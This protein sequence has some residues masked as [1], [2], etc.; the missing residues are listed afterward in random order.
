M[1]KVKIEVTQNFVTFFV[2]RETRIKSN[3]LL[4]PTK[5]VLQDTLENNAT[6]CIKE[7]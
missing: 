7:I 6:A 2:L 4:V 3:P 5:H 1:I